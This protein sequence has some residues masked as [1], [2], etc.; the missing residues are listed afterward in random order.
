MFPST[1]E[2]TCQAGRR[3]ASYYQTGRRRPSQAVYYEESH[4][5]RANSEQLGRARGGTRRTR[6]RKPDNQEAKPVQN[7]GQ[8]THS[9]LQSSR[10]YHLCI[11]VN[12]IF[13]CV[14]RQKVTKCRRLQ[15]RDVRKSR[16]TTPGCRCC[17][18]R[19]S[20]LTVRVVRW[21]SD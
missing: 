17:T 4:K 20:S 7:W 2:G 12:I 14:N 1:V 8:R 15:T 10:R 5:C 3:N 9:P 18:T 11:P 21:R 13:G 16:C 19:A 6:R